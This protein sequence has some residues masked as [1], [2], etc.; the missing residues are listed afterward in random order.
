MKH[1]ISVSMIVE[2][3]IEFIQ[4]CLDSIYELADE[5]VVYLDCHSDDGT[6][7]VLEKCDKV[8]IIE[9]KYDRNI[10]QFDFSKSRNDCLKKLKYDWTFIID[11]DE[12][13]NSD[14]KMIREFL[15]NSEPSVIFLC[16]VKQEANSLVPAELTQ[17][18]IFPTK[19]GV[20]YEGEVHNQVRWPKDKMIEGNL[21]VVIGHTGYGSNSKFERRMKR[22]RTILEETVARVEEDGAEMVDYYNLLKMSMAVGED[23]R[24][25]SFG[26]DGMKIYMESDP[27]MQR[28]MHRFLLTL[29]RCMIRLGKWKGANEILEIH[30]GVAGELVDSSFLF[31]VYHYHEGEM[32]SAM[33][34]GLKY[35]EL[36]EIERLTPVR[37]ETTLIYKQFVKEKVQM[38]IYFI[39]ERLEL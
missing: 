24:A 33:L 8:R 21:N 18:R 7:E 36:L 20:Y 15:M 12:Y 39:N 31:F 35:L 30:A 2:N 29:V 34:H 4:D 26:Q 9:N 22:T 32:I 28:T 5:I 13:L 14:A 16:E 17:H 19:Q 25:L 6:R 3:E 11:G 1:G 37:F 23:E 27:S 38:L 10:A